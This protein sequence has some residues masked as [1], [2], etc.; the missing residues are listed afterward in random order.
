M[1]IRV[2]DKVEFMRLVRPT[3]DRLATVLEGVHSAPA[4]YAMLS[5]VT[6]IRKRVPMTKEAVHKLID[7]LDETMSELKQEEKN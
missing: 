6:I 2:A 5:W 1:T 4:V 3:I 7:A